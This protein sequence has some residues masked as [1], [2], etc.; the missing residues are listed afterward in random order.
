MR[1][2]LH[3]MI[4]CPKR[5][6]GAV[7]RIHKN[8]TGVVFPNANE[9]FQILIRNNPEGGA[10]HFAM[11][12]VCIPN[13]EDDDMLARCLETYVGGVGFD[14]DEF[15]V[16]TFEFDTRKPSA[17]ELA[18]CMKRI[19]ELHA[20]T[21]CNC[22]KRFITDGKEMCLFCDLTATEEMLAET[23][24][25]ICLQTCLHMHSRTMACCNKKIHIL[26][27]A[28]WYTKGNK[29]CPMCREPLNRDT[30]P[31]VLEEIVTTLAEEVERH[32]NGF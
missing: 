19:N 20:T 18:E 8:D 10:G 4:S 27:D 2:T 17:E 7:E 31:T 30:P 28:N 3:K 32:L 21:I 25:P 14:G 11:I 15:I 26:C 24:C 9:S 22:G 23:E 12:D 16:H 6:W 1:T 13:D 5:L 29:K